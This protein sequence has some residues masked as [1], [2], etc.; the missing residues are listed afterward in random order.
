[1]WFGCFSQVWVV[2]AWWW[3]K[4]GK[5]TFWPRA[6]L[7]LLA[8]KQGTGSRDMGR[9]CAEAEGYSLVPLLCILMLCL[10]C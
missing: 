3:C 7:I 9:P 2:H 10:L 1:M 6:S 4:Q 5:S 8:G